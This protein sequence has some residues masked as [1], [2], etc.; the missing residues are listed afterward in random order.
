MKTALSILVAGIVAVTLAVSSTQSAMA[1]QSLLQVIHG[2]LFEDRT[3]NPVAGATVF[4]IAPSGRRLNRVQ[5][6]NKNGVFIMPVDQG[7]YKLRILRVGFDSVDTPILDV[8]PRTSVNV[9]Y[10][11]TPRSVFLKQKEEVERSSLERGREGMAKRE[12]LGKGKFIYERDI[13][14]IA[15]LPVYEILGR[16][17]GLQVVADGSIRTTMGHGCMQ[18][19]VNKLPVTE[20][21]DT[22]IPLDAQF[23]SLYQ[24]LPNGLDIAG[25]EV[26]R[27]FSEVPKE[28]RFDAWPN[29]PTERGVTPP[30][31]IGSIRKNIPIPPCGLVNIWTKAAW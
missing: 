21:P 6:T 15:N 28:F 23:A 1:Q 12:P 19:L 30:R 20:I 14:E 24:M 26:Y 17:E 29:A 4:L 8:K 18:Y 7:V 9:N 5:T 2:R 11:L 3:N 31:Y 10:A 25:M 13:R 16:V 22:Q 27:Q